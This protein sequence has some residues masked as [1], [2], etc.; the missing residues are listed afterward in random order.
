MVTTK[1]N[2]KFV[3]KKKLR[4]MSVGDVLIVSLTNVN[5]DG[6][7]VSGQIFSSKSTVRRVL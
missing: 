2:Y 4:G 7:A 1:F 5:D 6:N 3:R